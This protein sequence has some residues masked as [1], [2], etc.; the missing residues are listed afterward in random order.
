MA[1]QG[2]FHGEGATGPLRS[3]RRP[4]IFFSEMTMTSMYELLRDDD[5][6]CLTQRVLARLGGWELLV[7]CL[8]LNKTDRRQALPVLVD[9]LVRWSTPEEMAV[10]DPDEMFEMIKDCGLGRRRTDALRSVSAQ[11]AAGERPPGMKWCGKYADDSY[12][13]FWTGT[14]MLPEEVTDGELASYLR[15]RGEDGA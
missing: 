5:V 10:A 2:L 11:W 15:W 8:M 12:K 4:P 3:D 14:P 7:G 6:P 1:R 13:I 9:L